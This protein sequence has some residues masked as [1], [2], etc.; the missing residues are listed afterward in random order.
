MDIEDVAG[1]S[2]TL[3]PAQPIPT[4]AHAPTSGIHLS[5]ATG[6][7]YTHDL[8]FTRDPLRQLSSPNYR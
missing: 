5:V 4:H 6:V 8:A 1:D 3:S 7:F 2:L